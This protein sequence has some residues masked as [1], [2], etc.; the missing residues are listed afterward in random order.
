M[1]TCTDMHLRH[2]SS[3]WRRW[4]TLFEWR[5]CSLMSAGVI[6]CRDVAQLE[7]HYSWGTCSILSCLSSARAVLLAKWSVP[8]DVTRD[9]AAYTIA[10]SKQLGPASTVAW[11]CRPSW[12]VTS[13]H[14]PRP[15]DHGGMVP[16]PPT[17]SATM[18]ACHCLGLDKFCLT[19]EC[20]LFS[21]NTVKAFHR[22]WLKCN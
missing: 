1:D 6:C 14:S 10:I 2:S 16:R 8:N 22:N 9:S 13:Q 4:S 17:R 21:R 7:R 5:Q 12:C 11:G 3:S 20:N 15:G 19:Y 18:G